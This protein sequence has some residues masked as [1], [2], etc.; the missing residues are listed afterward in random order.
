MHFNLGHVDDDVVVSILVMLSHEINTYP[1]GDNGQESQE[2]SLAFM[3]CAF[4]HPYHFFL[5]TPKL[6]T[7]PALWSKARNKPRRRPGLGPDLTP[8]RGSA[9]GKKSK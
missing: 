8:F 3:S 2:A 6:G 7:G 9:A 1:D 5:S 4:F